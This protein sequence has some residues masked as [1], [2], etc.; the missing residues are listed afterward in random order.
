VFLPAFHAPDVV[1]RGGWDVVIMNPP[2]VGRKEVPG[3]IG[4]M[5]VADLE[6]HYGRTSDLM[7][8][9]GFRALQLVCAGGAL[10]MIFNDSIFTSD[11]ADEFRRALLADSAGSVTLH[12]A[13]RT[14]CFEGVAVNGGAIVAT[15]AFGTDREVRW[16]ENHGRPP[17]DLLGATRAAGGVGTVVDVGRSELFES[18]ARQFGRLPHRP[19]F[20]PSTPALLALDAFER[21]AGWR[22]FGRYAAPGGGRELDTAAQHSCA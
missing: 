5:R 18:D 19:L 16:V 14:R 13:A 15:R 21:C 22:D 20:R 12:A 2:Y 17:A 9:F 7:L 10:S 3:R 8:H 6:R 1:A 4:A 11:D